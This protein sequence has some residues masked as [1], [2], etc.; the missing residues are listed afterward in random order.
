[1]LGAFIMTLGLGCARESP[2]QGQ[3]LGTTRVGCG[4]VDVAA[5]GT[6]HRVVLTLRR[7]DSG[8]PPVSQFASDDAGRFSTLVPPGRYLLTQAGPAGFPP[9]CWPVPIDVASGAVVIADVH[10]SGPARRS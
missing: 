6:P 2:P 10:C 5:C 7:A 1:M 4:D 8:D 9:Q 3:I